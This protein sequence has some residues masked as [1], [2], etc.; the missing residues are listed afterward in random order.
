MFNQPVSEANTLTQKVEE[1]EGVQ[2]LEKDR[3]VTMNKNLESKMGGLED[4]LKTLLLQGKSGEHH[5][6]SCGSDCKGNHGKTHEPSSGPPQRWGAKSLEN[7]T[8][9]WCKELGHFAA[10]CPD[11][12]EQI[13]VGNIKVNAEGKL[14]LRDGSLIP[15][16]P[17]GISM[18]ERVARHYARKPSQFFYGEYDDVDPISTPTP[19]YSQYVGTS[20]TAE[21]RIARLEAELEVRRREESLELRKRK[22]E[23]DEK[24]LEQSRSNRAVNSLDLLGQLTDEEVLA[25]T[26]ARSGFP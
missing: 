18:K 4:L 8:C 9:F 24:K 17:Q 2:A 12:K 10:D 3:L 20:E 22:L 23:Q 14:R 19:T 15:N 26:A 25:I 21:Q 13:R 1:L 7:E 11:Q 5:H 16:Y 6:P